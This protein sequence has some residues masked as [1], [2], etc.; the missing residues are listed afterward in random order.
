MGKR[1]ITQREFR[2]MEIHETFLERKDL[3]LRAKGLRIARNARALT[4]G[5]VEARPGTDYLF[6]SGARKVIETQS[7]GSGYVALLIGDSLLQIMTSQFGVQFETTTVPWTDAMTVWAQELPGGILIGFPTGF[8]YLRRSNVTSGAW[9]LETVGFNAYWN[10]APGVEIDPSGY[11]GDITV[12]ASAPVF[13][14]EHVGGVIRYGKGTISVTGF[15]SATQINGVAIE[16][17]LT[18]DI[19]VASD[20]GFRFGDVVTGQDSGFLGYVASEPLFNVIRVVTIENFEGPDV[21]ERLSGP[22]S[23]TT[24]SSVAIVANPAP[25]PLWDEQLMSAARGYPTGAELA[26]GRLFL[27]GFPEAPSVIAASSVDNPFDFTDGTSDADAIIRGVGSNSPAFRHV[28]AASDLLFFSDRGIYVQELRGDAVLTP[29]TFRPFLVDERG[30]STITPARVADGV[31]FVEN[32]NKTLSAALLD[33]NVYLKWSVLPISLFHSQRDKTPAML[34][35]PSLRSAQA[36]R[37]LFVV[38]TD[39]TMGCVTWEQGFQQD[40]TGIAP[41]DTDGQYRWAAPMFGTH[42]FLVDRPYNPR[43]YVERLAGGSLVDCR[44]EGNPTTP[45][46]AA[47]L[48]LARVTVASGLRWVGDGNVSTA[49]NITQAGDA[50]FSDAVGGSQIGLPFTTDIGFWPV[51]VIEAP[52]AGLV[53]ARVTRFGVSVQNTGEFSV[54]LNA[55]TYQRGGY[56]VGD[57]LSLPPPRVTETFTFMVTGRPPH[58]DI[59]IRKTRPGIFRLLT[60]TQEVT[61]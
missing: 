52:Y 32:N 57:D 12:T 43:L 2:V 11:A 46:I 13:K 38:N 23:S 50:D 35:G 25:S 17:P 9:Q 40:I 21:S 55:K 3:D 26:S 56:S 59:R 41:W 4:S 36:E 44:V 47:H 28:I 49:G 60:A 30:A 7:P 42:W 16:L 33:G 24:V 27:C 37:Y 54:L 58:A 8:R 10:F 45:E 15:T 51:E 39:G 19:T 61:F 48:P 34:C 31:I 5:V 14:P 6:N 20:A 1:T 53:D 22:Q 29:S 18:F